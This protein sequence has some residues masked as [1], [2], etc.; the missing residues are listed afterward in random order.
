[1][2]ATTAAAPGT[3]SGDV[4]PVRRTSFVRDVWTVFSREITPTLREPLGLAFTMAQPLL[5]LF[6]FGPLL[7]GTGG[8]GGG[9][10]PWQ[11]FV[12]GILVLQCLF[13]PM[14]AGYN[15]LT[16]LLG[17]SL[18]RMMVSPLNRTAML[19]GRT[20]KE[21][22]LLV[23]QAVLIMALAV[24]MGFTVHAPGIAAGLVLLTVFGV[25]LG[26]LSFCLAMAAQPNGELFYMVT[27]MLLFPLLLLSGVLLPLD[28]GPAWLRAAAAANPVA[29]IADAERALF[30]GDFTDPSVA[31][32]ALAA[33]A[34]AVVG[35]VLGTRAMRK[36]V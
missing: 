7:G 33:V 10:A 21:S 29:Y 6:L 17:G 4:V 20:L 12:P 14:M 8:F 25:G 1:M 3:D 2:T 13:G 26:A 24:P 35:L 32:G 34:I 15:L 36:G 19:I 18:E 16:E 31:Y 30:A 28:F 27:Q 11:W 5:F 23:A 22:V 9:E